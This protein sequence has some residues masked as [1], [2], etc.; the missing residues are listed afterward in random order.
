[1]HGIRGWPRL[2]AS[3]VHQQEVIGTAGTET[4]VFVLWFPSLGSPETD[5]S[6]QLK[7]PAPFEVPLS[8]L[9]GS[10]LC[11]SK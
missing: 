10:V 7:V 1:M 11:T 9:P 6:P 3:G 2:P 5:H 8:L 4:G